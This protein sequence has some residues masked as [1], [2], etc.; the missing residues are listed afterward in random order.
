[1]AWSSDSKHFFYVKRDP[2]TL[3]PFQVY[4]HLIGSK[5]SEDVLIY[6]EKDPTFHVSVGNSR[7]MEFIEIDISS[8]T[9]S[10]TLLLKSSKPL[11]SPIVFFPRTFLNQKKG[12]S[13]KK[14]FHTEKTF[15]FS[16]FCLIQKI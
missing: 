7:S 2:E 10:E 11:E 3:L 1:M 14:S 15:Y 12:L 4:R 13:G 6:E 5:Q 16:Q 8:T 9:S